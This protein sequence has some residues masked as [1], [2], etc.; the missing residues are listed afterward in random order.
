MESFIAGIPKAELHLHLEGTLEPE[1]KVALAERNGVDLPYASAAEMRAAYDF[2]DLSS[3][4]AVYYEGMSVLR[5]EQDFTDLALA[6]FTKAASQNVV[7]AEVFFDPQ[8]HTSRGIAF[9]TVLTGI[10]KAQEEASERLGL[11]TQLIM[12]F[13]RDMSVE[14]AL[15][16]LEASL[17]HKEAI[18]GV[19]LDSDERNNPPA[20]FAAVFARA[21]E[22]GFR[23]T[24]HCDVDQDDSV[25]HIWQAVRDIEVERLDHGVNCLEDDELVA[26]IKRRDL[27]LT[28]CPISNSYVAASLKAEQIKQMLHRGLKVTIN[29]D[30]PA[31]FPGYVHENLVAVQAAADL[32][33]AEVVQLVR[34]AFEAAWVDDRARDEYLGA[35]DAYVAVS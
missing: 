13:L 15:E 6:Y 1:L 31:Y 4:L 20:K 2:D 29:S 12:C 9:E 34:N 17:P 26:E 23:I 30:D 19:G 7:Y 33:R 5:E 32:S 11:R 24:A 27:A 21:R 28:V 35:V 10:R 25:N 8:A 22:E 16:T 14:S 3:F 18:V